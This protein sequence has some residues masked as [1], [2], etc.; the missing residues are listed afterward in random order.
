MQARLATDYYTRP[1]R[2]V[3]NFARPSVPAR[4]SAAMV[5]EIS[6]DQDVQPSES[7]DGLLYGHVCVRLH[8]Q[9]GAAR[10][11]DVGGRLAEPRCGEPSADLLRTARDSA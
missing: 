5:A 8:G 9:R 10:V 4:T 7:L 6:V 11:L 1:E 2:S 3:S